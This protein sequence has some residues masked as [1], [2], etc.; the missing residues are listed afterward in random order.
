MADG[1]APT[2]KV[3]QA[4]HVLT[5]ITS[6][7]KAMSADGISKGR[8][9]TQQGYAFRGIDDVYNAL[10]SKLANHHL[11]VIPK[12]LSR[13]VVERTNKSGGALFYVTVSMEFS[14]LSSLDGTQI[15]VGPF[16]GEA[17]DSGD[18]A[19]NK[20]M[21]AAYKYMAMQTFCI[22][23]EGDNDADAVTHEVAAKEEETEDQR[24]DRELIAF[25]ADALAHIAKRDTHEALDHLKKK[26]E[27]GVGY[28]T[29]KERRPRD[30]NA[31]LMAIEQRHEDLG[32][33]QRRTSIEEDGV[34]F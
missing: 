33:R 10:A 31:I 15:T 17:M 8:K 32:P 19:T 14:F 13:D 11:V 20:A 2:I 34:P 5:A 30:A 23:T 1:N 24:M 16:L 7:M 27:A 4:P 26:I 25:K 9:N 21:S 3:T 28:A 18:K 29:L 12:V 22:P 6:V